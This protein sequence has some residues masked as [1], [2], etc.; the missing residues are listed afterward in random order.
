MAAP[1]RTDQTPIPVAVLSTSTQKRW[2]LTQIFHDQPIKLLRVFDEIKWF[3]PLLLR[4]N[5]DRL[6]RPIYGLAP[7]QQKGSLFA[8]QAVVPI[9]ACPEHRGILRAD[10]DPHPSPRIAANARSSV[11]HGEGS[12]ATQFHPI[13]LRKCL[14]DLVQHGI[15]NLLGVPFIQ[16]WAGLG[17]PLDQFRFE[18][19]TVPLMLSTTVVSDF[20]NYNHS[21]VVHDCKGSVEITG[22]WPWDEVYR[23]KALL[24]LFFAFPCGGSARGG[25]N[26]IRFARFQQPLKKIPVILSLAL[27]STTAT[28][29]ISWIR[30]PIWV[31]QH[32]P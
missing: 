16:M 31:F 6:C 28:W 9:L 24:Q 17:D 26:R 1:N 2:W 20:P 25:L 29:S 3:R 32:G 18:H 7:R 13:T 21:Q 8:I 11:L 30:L 15:D 14:R 12:E 22:G 10:R 5:A 27:M 23:G 4:Q 19:S